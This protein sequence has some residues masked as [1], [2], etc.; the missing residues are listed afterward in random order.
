MRG[1]GLQGFNA[2]TGKEF[3]EDM[4]KKQVKQPEFVD[5][6]LPFGGK[7]RADNRWVEL[8][9]L[10]P[11]DA[12]EEE[13]A[14]GLSEEQGRPALSA[15]VA[16]GTLIVKERLGTTDRETMEQIR[17]NPYLQYFLGYHEYGEELPFDATMLV[18][19]RK[20][21]PLESWQRLSDRLIMDAQEESARQA[22]A[23][24]ST[25]SVSEDEEPLAAVGRA[26]S[27]K[28]GPEQSEVKKSHGGQLI[29]DATAAPC[30]I[31]HPRDLGLV[32]E[33][34]EKSEQ[35]LDELY[36]HC[37]EAIKEKPRSYREVA[38]RRFARVARQKKVRREKVRQELNWQL[39]CVERNLKNIDT[40]LDHTALTVLPPRLQRLLPVIRQVACEQ[41]DRWRFGGLV[42]Q[43]I[44][45]LSQP[46][47]RAI[48][49]GKA[50][51]S[52]EFGPKLS[53]SVA[54]GF[55]CVDRLQW[56]PYNECS[57]LLDQIRACKKR[58]GVYPE[59]VL[60]DR[61]YRTRN[62]RRICK[63]LKIRLSALPLGRPGSDHSQALK[64]LAQDEKDRNAVEGKI[65]Q[66]KRRF[67]LNRLMGKLKATCESIVGCIFFCANLLRCQ[68]LGL[69]GLFLRLYS[70]ASPILH[71]HP[72]LHIPR[73]PTI[74]YH[75]QSAQTPALS[76]NK[77][78]A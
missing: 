54:N 45:S 66:L 52:F 77:K 61:I 19:F 42:K 41:R 10:V 17:E 64:T 12:V 78:A 50:A 1:Y 34:R 11:W 63:W 4:L 9:R 15:R 65:G 32:N 23:D 37:R 13:Y 47:I 36:A 62:N 48:Y 7:L 30:D 58:F 25:V 24:G 38:R 14:K 49:R 53:V 60:A 20:R 74:F 26:G 55:A 75:L 44:Y 3:A 73:K 8:S 59:S 6:Y 33:A 70:R 31:R 22:E 71:S 5:F 18:H 39:N 2:I 67:S 46:H 27:S 57:D 72:K 16:V 43:T 76:F 56:T 28:K 69:K 40:L 29:I 68:A 35:I 51:H 21:F